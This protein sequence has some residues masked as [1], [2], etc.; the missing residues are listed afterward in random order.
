MEPGAQQ[1]RTKCRRFIKFAEPKTN[2]APVPDSP[3]AA[4]RSRGCHGLF[5]SL[6]CTA[7]R[8]ASVFVNP[9]RAFHWPG[10]VCLETAQ[11]PNCTAHFLKP[12]PFQCLPLS[13]QQ[14]QHLSRLCMHTGLSSIP[15]SQCW[16]SSLLAPISGAL[17]SPRP[18]A[19]RHEPHAYRP[20]RSR[21][22]LPRS[23]APRPRRSESHPSN[24]LAPF[25]R[26]P[27]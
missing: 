24:L 21:G 2:Q 10:C 17:R 25:P 19:R 8:T 6:T 5:L 16:H 18:P 9:A 4:E 22:R 14:Q 12:L 13:L 20:N 15:K 3:P 7:L 1:H 26:L 11:Q 27:R 23:G